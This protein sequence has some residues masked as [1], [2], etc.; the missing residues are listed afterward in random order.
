[1]LGSEHARNALALDLPYRH[2]MSDL[3]IALE[4][5]ILKG[6]VDDINYTIY[7]Y[8]YHYFY[9]YLHHFVSRSAEIMQCAF[10]TSI[11]HINPILINWIYIPQLLHWSNASSGDCRSGTVEISASEA[12]CFIL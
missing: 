6:W 1:M 8:L 9:H 11:H 10:K 3:M 5:A 7:V 12:I 4:A 2:W